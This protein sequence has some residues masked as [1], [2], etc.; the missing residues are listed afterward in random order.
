MKKYKKK[1]LE[2]EAIRFNGENMAEISEFTGGRILESFSVQMMDQISI[3]TPSG[4]AIG[5]KGDW[6]VRADVDD[7]YPVSDKTFRESYEVGDE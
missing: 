5:K 3:S 7:F 6:I 1:S 4:V 2:R